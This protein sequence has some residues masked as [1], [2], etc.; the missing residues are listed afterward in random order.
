MKINTRIKL[1]FVIYAVIPLL[2]AAISFGIISFAQ[3]K[4]L[5]NY[6]GIE[7]ED[8][9]E[10][11]STAILLD[12]ISESAIDEV[13][14]IIIDDV[15][16]LEDEEYL[17]VMNYKLQEK[18]SFIITTKNNR[19]NFAEDGVAYRDF[20]NLLPTYEEI[21]TGKMKSF[22]TSG[23]GQYLIKAEKF[24]YAD[25]SIGVVYI[26]SRTGVQLEEINIFIAEIVVITVLI[27]LLTGMLLTLWLHKAIMSPLHNLKRATV[28]IADGNLDF[29]VKKI[30]NDE[31]GE[32]SESFEIMRGK[33]K[34][35][36]EANLAYDR[37][38]KELI[39]NISHDLKT[40]ITSIKGYVEGL[41]DGVATTPEKQEKYLRTIY[42]KSVDMDRLI[43]ELTLYSQIDTNKIPYNFRKVNIVSYMTDFCEET[44][45]DFETRNMSITLECNVASDQKVVADVEQFRRVINNIVGNSVKYIDKSP[46]KVDIKINDE[47]EFVH[48]A[49]EDNGQGIEKENLPMIFERF[50]RTDASRNSSK[51][52]SGIGLAIVKK[53][54]EAH[55]GKIWA[56]SEVGVGTTIH[57]TLKKAE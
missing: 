34:E 35:T 30:N 32:L 36:I 9:S 55:D 33:L 29:T 50:Y 4:S 28:K 46:G 47:G 10:V 24:N 18:Y 16:V 21:G 26:V 41:L 53:I 2:L 48:I 51:G 19:V 56:E 31:F 44:E 37:E 52:G 39:S 12:K 54:I 42:N 45:M 7:I 25:G 38:S 20:V 17:K 15:T 43:G 23:E 8:I 57:F 40:P 3:K 6:Y 22:Y 11:F 27:L 14:R 13:R 1:S 5:E 49:I